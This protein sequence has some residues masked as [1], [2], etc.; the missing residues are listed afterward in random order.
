MPYCYQI[1]PQRG[2]LLLC[3]RG[4]A[5][6]PDIVSASHSNRWAHPREGRVE[7]GM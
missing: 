3:D 5:P 4:T 2:F 1:G 6:A 7:S